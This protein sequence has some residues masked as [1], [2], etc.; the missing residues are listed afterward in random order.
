M[1]P[2]WGPKGASSG[3][4]EAPSGAPS[5]A[6]LGAPC[7]PGPYI[8]YRVYSPVEGPACYIAMYIACATQFFGF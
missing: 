3:P 4:L 2:S 6:P 7:G 8:L 1:N 5:G